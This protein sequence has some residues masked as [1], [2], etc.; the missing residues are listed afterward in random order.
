MDYFVFTVSLDCCLQ[1]FDCL[2]F[3]SNVVFLPSL[4]ATLLKEKT[5]NSQ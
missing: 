3:I 4:K 5:T 1:S 2:F